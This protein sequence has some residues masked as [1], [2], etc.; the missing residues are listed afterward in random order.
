ME[1]KLCVVKDIEAAV[2]DRGV[3]SPRNNL[4]KYTPKYNNPIVI[5]FT[6]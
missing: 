2:L 1:T 5:I 4:H 6:I 3:N